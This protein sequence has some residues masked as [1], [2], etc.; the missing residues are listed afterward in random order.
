MATKSSAKKS[1]QGTKATK[2][3]RKS[4]DINLKA[5]GAGYATKDRSGN[6]TYYKNAGD[7]AGYNDTTQSRSNMSKGN[8]MFTKDAQGKVITSE[9]LAPREKINLPTPPAVNPLTGVLDTANASLAGSIGGTYD[10]TTKQM[11]APTGDELFKS[12]QAANA[13]AF[14]EM[15]S[16]EDRL[17]EQQRMLRPKEKAVNSLTAQLNTITANRDA[18]MLALEGQGRGV[19]ESIIGGQQAQISREAAIQAMPIQAQLAVAQ[20]DLE[21]ARSY[22][23]QLFQA[24]SQDAL[25]KY[26]YQKELNS[27][28]YNFLDSQE[29]ARLAKNEKELDRQFQI[30]QANRSTLKQL[31]M[32]AIEYGQGAL[33][34]EIMRLDPKSQTFDTDFGDVSSRLRKPV[35]ASSTA[36]TATGDSSDL[37]AYA[38]QYSSTGKLPTPSEM[39]AAGL[40]VGQVTQYAKQTPRPAGALVNANTGVSDANL[41]QAEQEDIRRLY[42]IVQ[43]TNELEALDKQRIGGVVAGS[44]GKVFGSDAQG[45][46]LTKR[47][48]IVDEI[49]RMQ[50][51]AALTLD[52]QDFYNSY[53][54]GRFSESFFLGRDSEDVI[55]NFRDEMNQKLSNALA[56]NGLSMYGFSTVDVNGTERKVGEVIEISGMKLRVLPDGTL[57][58]II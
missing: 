6:V 23:S 36:F 56:N 53:L 34:G 35:A 52:E 22:A 37:A 48:S 12:Y 2:L 43:M 17:K 30:E 24:Q 26:N 20:S 38:N 46:Y 47:K 55:K 19:T 11:T 33:A 49:A 21:S 5:N 7:A 13:S 44:L 31:S 9:S 41:G 45:S 25:A 14:S 58:D 1:A 16:S 28:I 3:V 39:K 8:A 29:K 10:T 40:T 51:G 4:N 42:N 54:P 18:E 27:S 15:Q 32:Q 50:T 57:T